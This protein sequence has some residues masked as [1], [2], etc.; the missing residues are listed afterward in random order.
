[1]DQPRCRTA[2]PSQDGGGIMAIM[3]DKG[4]RP[5]AQK[6]R[7]FGINMDTCGRPTTQPAL[8]KGVKHRERRAL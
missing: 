4:A 3:H 1:M 7:V 8:R 2:A 5:M 6:I